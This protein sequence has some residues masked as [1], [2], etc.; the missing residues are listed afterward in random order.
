AAHPEFAHLNWERL[1][2]DANRIA[3]GMNVAVLAGAVGALWFVFRAWRNRINQTEPSR[4]N[5]LLVCVIF[6]CAYFG[7]IVFTYLTKN[8]TDIW[9]RYGLILFSL[10][11]P[12]LAYTAQQVFKS[13]KLWAQAALGFALAMGVAQLRTQTEDLARFITQHARPET[14]A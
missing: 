6:F 5:N 7:F 11:L 8:N 14:I 4:F 9:P 12:L 13:R 2:I 3:Y 1:W 10:G